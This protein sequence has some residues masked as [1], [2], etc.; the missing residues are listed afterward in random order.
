MVL[1]PGVLDNK[2]PDFSIKHASFDSDA[3]REVVLP[4]SP[5]GIHTAGVE[6]LWVLRSG[7]RYGEVGHSGIALFPGRPACSRSQAARMSVTTL[8]W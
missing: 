1:C 8:Y 6:Y 7:K 4:G 2:G 3:D 5:P